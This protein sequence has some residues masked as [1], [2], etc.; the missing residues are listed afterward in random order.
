MM[1]FNGIG[2]FPVKL[3]VTGGLKETIFGASH[4]V[5]FVLK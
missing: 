2:F 5:L 4:E 3:K 1:V